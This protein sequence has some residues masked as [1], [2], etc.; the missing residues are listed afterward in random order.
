MEELFLA[1]L[2]IYWRL[3][4]EAWEFMRFDAKMGALEELSRMSNELYG[5][6]SSYSSYGSPFTGNW[7]DYRYGHHYRYR[8]YEKRIAPTIKTLKKQKKP[9]AQRIWVEK[10]L[11]SFSSLY[12]L[13]IYYLIAIAFNTLLP[14]SP[15]V[16]KEGIRI[17]G[18]LIL[19]LFSL[20]YYMF[21]T[22]SYE[23]VISII[24][25]LI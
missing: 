15:E 10:H 19:L 21:H 6:R 8:E 14:L 4:D 9:S 23:S 3:Q 22:E 7:Y 20:L 17:Y 5:M 16:F 12:A 18:A 13:C 11:L 2:R 1:P 25:K 24:D